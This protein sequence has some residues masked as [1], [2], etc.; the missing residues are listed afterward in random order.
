MA[1]RR[2]SSRT[3]PTEQE[4]DQRTIEVARVTRVMAG[5]KRMRFRACVVIGNRK[6]G[7]GYGI[8]KGADVSL[9]ISKATTRA[10]RDMV[11]IP[12][13]RETIPHE[14]RIKFKAA[15]II[16]K[17]APSGTGIVAGGAVREALEISGI[18]N[19][20]AKVYGSKN[21]INNIKALFSAFD[22]LQ[23]SVKK[24]SVLRHH[25]HRIKK[26]KTEEV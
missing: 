21:K 6:G 15:R 5:G 12:I 10:R 25:L 1:E 18:H 2:G 22:V 9:A 16:L 13:E 11:T 26:E 3:R 8:G 23:S 20:V 17:P 7:V 14:L 19:I 24:Q 4:F